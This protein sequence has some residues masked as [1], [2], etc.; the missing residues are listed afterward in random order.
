M[1]LHFEKFAQEGNEFV[2]KLAA[3][4]GH[5]GERDRV[6]L[7][8]KA[9][10]HTLRERITI[11]ESFHL[12]SQLPM[13]LKATYVD[14]WKYREQPENYK[15]TTEFLGNVERLQHLQGERAF[16]WSQSTEELTRIVLSHLGEMITEG[17]AEHVLSNLPE[18]IRD[19]VESAMVK[20]EVGQ[21]S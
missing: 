17:Q 11:P 15:T 18:E 19:F 12:L 14:Q 4:L 13:F 9:V 16:S 3:D 20:H 21:S 8:L 2:N 7:L 10:L 6:T 5:P 1:A